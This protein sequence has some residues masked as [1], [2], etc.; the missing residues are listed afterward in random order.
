MN[1]QQNVL[2]RTQER[3]LHVESNFMSVPKYVVKT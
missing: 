3:E 2:M 1:K